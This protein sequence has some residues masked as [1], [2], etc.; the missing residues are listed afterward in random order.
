M[1]TI[2]SGPKHLI[3]NRRL[4]KKLTV[5]YTTAAMIVLL[6]MTLHKLYQTVLVHG[7]LI[8]DVANLCQCL[9]T[10]HMLDTCVKLVEG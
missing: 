2:D 5:R 6:V 4:V 9:H 3:N 8:T 7:L 1:K 10:I